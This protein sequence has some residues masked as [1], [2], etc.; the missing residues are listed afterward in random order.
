MSKLGTTR[1]AYSYYSYH[2]SWTQVV[3]EKVESMYHRYRLVQK[4]GPYFREREG[5]LKTGFPDGVSVPQ[6][7]NNVIVD[8]NRES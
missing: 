6:T 4:N 2:I 8:L 7:R 1:I 5:T 3:G